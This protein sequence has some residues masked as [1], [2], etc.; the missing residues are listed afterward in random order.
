MCPQEILP[1]TFEQLEGWTHHVDFDRV[2]AFFNETSLLVGFEGAGGV[3][4]AQRRRA[5][6]DFLL[7]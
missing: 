7:Y 5:L 4:I 6:R 2:A 1:R 3:T